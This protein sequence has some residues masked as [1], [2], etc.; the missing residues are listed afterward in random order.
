[1]KQLKDYPFKEWMEAA[2]GCERCGAKNRV[3]ITFVDESGNFGDITIEY[4]HKDNCPIGFEDQFSPDVDVAGWEFS[5]VIRKIAG[6]EFPTLKSRINIGVCL[7][8]WKFITGVPIMLFLENS[9]LQVDFCDSCTEEL[10]I[11]DLLVK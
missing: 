9:N 3:M 8:C 5:Q 6:K 4:Q 7:N 2:D 1:M 10:G 11:L